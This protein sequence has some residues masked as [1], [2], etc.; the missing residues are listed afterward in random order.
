MMIVTVL[1]T[2]ACRMNVR[3]GV[4]PLMASRW[5]VVSCHVYLPEIKW[6]AVPSDG[7][8]TSIKSVCTCMSH[9]LALA[10]AVPPDR[11]MMSFPCITIFSL[12]L[13]DSLKNHC[14][15]LAVR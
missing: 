12:L 9:D 11:M 3:S 13:L 8:P 5:L 15:L 14:R 6:C 4:L 2:I 10:I 1:L 7:L